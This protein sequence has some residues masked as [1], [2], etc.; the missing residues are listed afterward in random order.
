M[1]RAMARATLQDDR[2]GAG[3]NPPA[4]PLDGGGPLRR[5][6]VGGVR[7]LATAAGEQ[8]LRARG[9]GALPGGG[10]SGEFEIAPAERPDAFAKYLEWTCARPAAGPARP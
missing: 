6:Q 7:W 3:P 1:P 8:V 9:G 10:L 5:L 4:G 2:P